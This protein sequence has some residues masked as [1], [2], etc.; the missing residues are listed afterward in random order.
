MLVCLSVCHSVSVSYYFLAFVPLLCT[1][2]FF[3]SL[4]HSFIFSF[5][6]F[7][8]YPSSLFVRLSLCLPITLF[9]ISLFL[10][11]A[12]FSLSSFPSFLQIS[13]SLYLSFL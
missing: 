12:N 4:L 13:F 1:S 9:Q 11:L 8:I 6:S 2:S 5:S 10:S 3:L 7:P